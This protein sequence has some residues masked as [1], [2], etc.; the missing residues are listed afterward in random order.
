MASFETLTKLTQ[1]PDWI[2]PRSEAQVFLG[3]PGAPEASK[4][5]VEP[6]NSFS[7]GMRTFGVTWWLRFRDSSTFFAPE[8]APLETL[9]WR[10]EKGYLPIIH[11]NTQIEGLTAQH[12]IFQDGNS[13]EF[14]E[15]VCGRLLLR[16]QKQTEVNVQV[17][18]ALRS[19]GPSGGPIRDLKVGP[20][21]KSFHLAQRN[22]PLLGSDLSPNAIGC[23]T[24]DPSSQ[25]MQG[26]VPT[27]QMVQDSEGWCFGLMSFDIRLAEGEM[28]QLHFDC[29]IQ[30]YGN[31]LREVPSTAN[32]RPAEYPSRLEAHLKVWQPLLNQ[33]EL[34]VPDSQFK[35]AY[36]A[37]LQH[38]L[39]ATV[40]DQARISPLTYP[41]PWLR[42]SVYIIR[43]FDLAGLHDI[44]RRTSSYCARNDFFGGF[45]A[46]GD[47]PGQGIWALVQHYRITRD[48]SWLQDIYPSIH[49]K[50]SW[51]FKMRR[52]Q[53]PIQVVVDTPVL[54]FTHAE[55]AAGIICTKAQDGIIYG[56][57]DHGIR[58]ALGW[59]N[60]WAL[61]GL[62]EAAYASRELGYEEDA[63][64]Y[65]E[66]AGDLAVALKSFIESTPEFFD[67]ERSVNSVLW[68]TRSW[69]S[70]PDVVEAGFNAWWDSHRGNEEAYRPE[71]YWLY[72]ELA[73]AHNALLLGQPE[74]AWQVLQ[75]RLSNQDVPGLFGWREGR[76]GVGT[77]NA[78]HGVTLINQLRGC[79]KLDSITPHGWSQAELWLLQRAM[80]VEEWQG[81]LLL[82]AGVPRAWLKTNARLA[83]RKFP[84]WFGEVNADLIIG[85]DGHSATITVSGADAGTPLLVRLAG[86]EVSGTGNGSAAVTLKTV[87]R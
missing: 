49:R 81:G 67:W 43:C 62:R 82:F 23:G 65:E 51:L 25:A 70:A 66:E 75:Y 35:H 80:L 87:L 69:E 12:T 15:A 2:T 41:L 38:M 24:G 22:L 29:P 34:E 52:A 19:L 17:F 32:L 60:H 4:T 3:E 76:D 37:G 14:S 46:E 73:Q 30:T 78:I 47:A 64:R 27:E 58:H 10:Y 55:R 56:A 50:C 40:G 21:K 84:T 59:V 39:T 85:E 28:W 13:T 16:N 45:G 57:M 8:H 6:G 79:H 68:P 48:K 61:C 83:F 63:G 36:F 9:S 18:L 86:Q 1:H 20:D 77:E 74:K 72:F 44:A 42:D 26:V 53:N 54:A 33:V 5:T 11:C 71:N 31:L 7:P